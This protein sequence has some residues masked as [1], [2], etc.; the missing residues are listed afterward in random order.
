MKVNTKDEIKC[1]TEEELKS[2][3]AGY[4]WVPYVF[5]VKSVSI[6]GKIFHRQIYKLDRLKKFQ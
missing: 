2:G 6:N 3:K 5:S 4:I 1:L